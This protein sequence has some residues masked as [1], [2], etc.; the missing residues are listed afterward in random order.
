M[1]TDDLKNVCLL[2]YLRGNQFESRIY[3][4][5]V[6]ISDFFRACYKHLV[7]LHHPGSDYPNDKGHV[8]EV[9]LCLRQYQDIRFKTEKTKFGLFRLI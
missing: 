4:K 1:V 3:S 2:S 8:D 5:D 7:H 6:C 9:S